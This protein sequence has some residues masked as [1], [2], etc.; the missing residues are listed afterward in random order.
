MKTQHRTWLI[1][2]FVAML[3][4]GFGIA[5]W[6][7][8]HLAD[9]WHAAHEDEGDHGDDDA[10]DGHGGE[11]AEEGVVALGA[12]QISASGI[13]VVPVGRGGGG[14]ET[15]LSGRVEPAI[16]ARAVVAAAIAGRVERVL[17]A[18]GARVDAGAAL[19]VLVSG[20]AATLRAN[21]DAA[22]AEADAVRLVFKR[23]ESLAA[24][25][26]VARQELETSRARSLAADAAARAAAAQ[27][28]AAGSPDAE[29]RVTVVSPA[30]GVVGTVSAMPGGVVSAGDVVAHVTDPSRTELVFGAPPLLAS[31][32]APGMRIDVTGPGGNFVATVTG[33]VADVRD[34][35]GT[36]L[37]RADA[38]AAVLPP[39]GA[40][41]AGVIVSATQ[42]DAITVPTDAVQTVDGRAVV[43]V[44]VEG[45]FRVTPVLAGRRAGGR[46]EVL[47]GL[48]GDERIAGSN[49]FLL[50][51]ELARGEADH[52]H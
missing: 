51:A 4:A 7:D 38:D 39:A 37:I 45:G 35:A 3:A 32:V 31:Q 26:I 21:A 50:K 8:P 12:D 18:P 48:T 17:V 28:R 47:D 2:A 20:E 44:A 27:L 42:G 24:Q 41:I 34:A 10:H 9:G 30:A 22:R 33:V 36:A 11:A 49:A 5:R 25:G 29:G 23:D 40:A 13:D 16:G 14:G 43:F 52:G 6:T 46:I 15:R 19:A 1:V